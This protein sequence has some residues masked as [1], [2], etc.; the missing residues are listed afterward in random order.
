MIFGAVL[1]IAP[2][3]PMWWM[4]V[5]YG[6]YLVILVIEVWTLFTDHP[7]IHK[8]ACTAASTIGIFEGSA[9]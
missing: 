1:V 2:T 9:M 6:G 5:F 4:G 3:S 8:Y 7:Q